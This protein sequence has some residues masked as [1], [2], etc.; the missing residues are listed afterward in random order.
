MYLVHNSVSVN[1]VVRTFLI[2]AAKLVTL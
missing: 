1:F 2:S